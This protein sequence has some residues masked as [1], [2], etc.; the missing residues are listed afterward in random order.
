[1][2]EE[3]IKRSFWY[4]IFWPIVIPI[5]GVWALFP[6]LLGWY[7]PTFVRCVQNIA[8][9]GQFGDSY[10]ALNTLFSGLAFAGVLVAIFLQKEQ[11]D[12][13]RQEMV[14]MRTV[15]VAQKQEM[16]YQ[17][18][19]LKRQ[20]FEN[21]F[22]NLLEHFKTSTRG[23]ITNRSD[24]N[25]SASLETLRGYI[26]R[27]DVGKKPTSSPP[28]QSIRRGFDQFYSEN[29]SKFRPYVEQLGNILLFV[30]KSQL[31]DKYF[32]A[33]VLF[34]QLSSAELVFLFY[35]YICRDEK[36]RKLLN[37][38]GFSRHVLASMLFHETH[39]SYYT[40]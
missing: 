14:E 4:R 35:F 29:E 24:E 36:L 2:T 9:R 5:F 20:Q 19:T 25:L 28:I 17:S 21:T 34:T 15:V 7:M 22:F 27:E 10:G 40:S 6:V 18:L 30:E 16:E 39:M 3:K 1:M 26:G 13:Q 32:Y 38:G 33:S 11:L 12:L 8:E 37:E 31:D 23:T